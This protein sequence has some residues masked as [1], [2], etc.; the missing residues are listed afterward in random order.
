M[1]QFPQQE[2][3]FAMYRA[4]FAFGGF[5]M[6]KIIP[7]I[8]GQITQ[9]D[10]A[11]YIW[12]SK[13]R[14]SILEDRSGHLHPITRQG[15]HEQR[16]AIRMSRMI[17]KAPNGLQIEH[18]DMDSLNNQRLNLRLR[19]RTKELTEDEIPENLRP[20]YNISSQEIQIAPDTNRRFLIIERTC[21]RCG[22]TEC[23]RVGDVRK[24]VH[25]GTL[26][27]V[28]VVCAYHVPH[29]HAKGEANWNWRGGRRTTEAGYVE[30]YC[31]EHPRTRR[32]YMFEHRF[33][34]EQVLGRLLSK[35]ERV[36]HKNGIRTD[37]RIDNL[38]IWS[39]THP[40]GMRHQDLT[41]HELEELISSLQIL[42]RAKKR[43]VHG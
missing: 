20:A 3:R 26:K 24:G 16:K 17:M 15:P 36:H 14:W 39:K 9:V 5:N 41:V 38:E 34:M 43:E 32:G 4:L 1:A 30:I 37:N 13:Y 11:D 6:A 29:P 2:Q 21:L 42:L 25:A 12:L 18:V 7:L 10:D 27:G 40:Y 33:V 19:I 23:A 22:K 35:N 28:C 31:G 8:N